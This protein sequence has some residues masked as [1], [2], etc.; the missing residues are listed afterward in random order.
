[1]SKHSVEEPHNIHTI[2]EAVY[3]YGRALFISYYMKVSHC[4]S[5]WY[6]TLQ[7]CYISFLSNLNMWVFFSMPHNHIYCTH[8]RFL[9]LNMPKNNVK[10]EKLWNDRQ[11]VKNHRE[12]N[13]ATFWQE[14]RLSNIF[15]SLMRGICYYKWIFFTSTTNH[16]LLHNQKTSQTNV[17]TAKSIMHEKFET[18]ED[19]GS[20]GLRTDVMH[21]KST[22]LYLNAEINND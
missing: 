17:L 12:I 14:I 13:M 4:T 2:H 22:T 1:M 20:A 21:E 8:S 18:F 9:S 10:W 15:I 19:Q 7:K 11:R 6:A 16:L 5:I 3:W